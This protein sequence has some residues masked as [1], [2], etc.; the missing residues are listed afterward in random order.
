MGTLE[1]GRAFWERSSK[2]NDYGT[3]LALE[4]LPYFTDGRIQSMEGLY[5]ESSATTPFHFLTA[6]E[7]AKEPSNPVRGLSYRTIAD[8]NLGV[9]HLRLLGVR[10][11]MA[12]S[13][14]AK[15]VAD[16]HPDMSLVAETGSPEVAPKVARW[17]IYE[18]AN[19]DLVEPLAFEPVVMKPVVAP[20]EWLSPSADWFNDPGAIDRHLAASG[21]SDWARVAT[22]GAAYAPRRELPRVE[23][24]SIQSGKDE[25][26]FRVSRPGVPILVKTSYFP[27][28][29]AKGALGPYRVTPNFMVV[30]PTEREVSLFYSRTPVDLAGLGLSL[31]GLAGLVLLARRWPRRGEPA[32]ASP[33]GRAP[34][35][36]PGADRVSLTRADEESAALTGSAPLPGAPTSVGPGTA[37]GPGTAR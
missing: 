13:D 3:D 23:V 26:S 32:S 21:P 37:G 10:Y 2:L 33:D 35:E 6:A 4:L 16:A 18:V 9:R 15:A 29:K 1:P 34:T 19:S 20:G 25:I 11:F 36:E 17:R 30:V 7:V 14:E 5:F 28:W 12:A 31:G 24:D 27:N 8:F 22:A